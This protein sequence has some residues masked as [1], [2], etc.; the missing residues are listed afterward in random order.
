MAFWIP[1]VLGGSA[2]AGIGSWL[3]DVDTGEVIEGAVEGVTAQIPVVIEA[4]VPA[5]MEGV[6]GG[7]EAVMDSF[8][9]RE[10]AFFT[11]LTVA[12]LSYVAFRSIKQMTAIPRPIL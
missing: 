9:G 6:L 5:L 7:I 2:V 3:F 12:T 8:K 1:L 10:I 4:T 11:G